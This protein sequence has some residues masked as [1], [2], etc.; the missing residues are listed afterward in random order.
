MAASEH[1]SDYDAVYYEPKI[2]LLFLCWVL[3]TFG[4]S[5]DG[6]ILSGMLQVHTCLYAQCLGK[7]F[8]HCE[9]LFSI[10]LN[11]ALSKNEKDGLPANVMSFLSLKRMTALSL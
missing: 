7:C 9:H 11:E 8:T 2:P 4:F 3:F 5:L 10:L 1:L 6:F